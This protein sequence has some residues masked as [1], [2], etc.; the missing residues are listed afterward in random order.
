MHFVPST[1]PYGFYRQE[2]GRY[3]RVFKQATFLATRTIDL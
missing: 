2:A 1:C 3:W